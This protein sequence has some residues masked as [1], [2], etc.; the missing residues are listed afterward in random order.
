MSASLGI[1]IPQAQFGQASIGYGNLS[2][3]SIVSHSGAEIQNLAGI[4]PMSRSAQY[5]DYR[6]KGLI[7]LIYDGCMMSASDFNV[8]SPQTVD[9]G[10]VVEIID[11]T[12]F[13]LTSAPPTLGEGPGAVAGEGT[14][15]GGGTYT[16]RDVSKT[17]AAGKNQ[18]FRGSGRTLGRDVGRGMNIRKYVYRNNPGR[19]APTNPNLAL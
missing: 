14:G 17:F 16:G 5:Q 18:V 7:N 2:G 11:T 19:S 9:G 3:E 1:K 4:S 13:V 6:A 15:R 8:D 12:P 10:P